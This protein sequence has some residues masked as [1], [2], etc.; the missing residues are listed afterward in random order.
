MALNPYF[1]NYQPEQNLVEDITVEVIKATGINCIYVPREYLSIDRVFGED[2]G[3][4]FKDSYTIEMYLQSYKGFEGTDV[5]S[6]FGLEIRDKVLLVL[7]R[8][9]FKEE[10]TNKNASIKR[11]REGD[12]IYFPLSK[13]LFE[14]NFVEH[15]N[16]LYPLGKLYSYA[17]TAELF[18]YSY[19]KMATSN[20]AINEVYN[21]T[22]GNA[23]IDIIPNNS[24]L[25]TTAGINDVLQ[26]E[27]EDYGFD[28]NDPNY[29][30]GNCGGDSAEDHTLVIFT[31]GL[32]VGSGFPA[33]S[34]TSNILGTGY[35]P[36]GRISGNPA[37]DSAL[38]TAA[39]VKT[40]FEEN[41]GPLG[42]RAIMPFFIN[43]APWDPTQINVT[44]AAPQPRTVDDAFHPDDF[45][46]D[47]ANPSQ[48]VV[49]SISP[50][51]SYQNTAKYAGNLKFASPWF[52]ASAPRTKIIWENWLSSLVAE[53]ITFD[54][55]M[56]NLVDTSVFS[57]VSYWAFNTLRET[58]VGDVPGKTLH[59]NHILNDPRTQSITSG[60]AEL[61]GS[62][63]DQLKINNGF[64]LTDFNYADAAEGVSAGYV[65]WNFVMSRL[66]SDYINDFYY[67]PIA[68]LM[69]DAQVSNYGNFIVKKSTQ[70]SDFA[71]HKQYFDNKQGNAVGAICYGQMGQIADNGQVNP[72]TPSILLYV[73][74][75]QNTNKF[76]YDSNNNKS[77]WRCMQLDQQSLKSYVRDGTAYD[78]LHVWVK[79]ATDVIDSAFGGN[80][81]VVKRK[82][83]YRENVYHICMIDPEVIF[84]FNQ[85]GGL[86]W[87]GTQMFNNDEYLTDSIEEVNSLK[88]NKRATPLSQCENK[89]D[90]SAHFLAS[91]CRL[92]NG[93]NLFRITTNY[94]KVNTLIV[95]G[96]SYDV[97]ETPGIWYI[98]DKDII[99]FEQTSYN[100]TTK[101]LEIT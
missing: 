16:P 17:I 37:Y 62:L 55:F 21:K 4:K 93:K 58:V 68:S 95:R 66:G 83:Y 98:A 18:T 59:M 34:S 45:C 51:P 99:D 41:P 15:E 11:P 24:M 2:P 36:Y 97:S 23:T 90:Y 96:T 46:R 47:P 85:Y 75:D 7:S 70:L 5:I 86:Q 8:K 29:A 53:G 60:N 13:S 77:G 42:K 69:P 73:P 40:W 25:G 84:Y 91:G 49:G 20:A 27:A 65:H 94:D 6:Q 72:S 61:Y 88:N 44:D 56:G 30:C 101:T 39:E 71:G 48:Y 12:L 43:S 67:T 22:R 28:P 74:S 89:L 10:V 26:D 31:F 33:W 76:G 78:H 57:P 82:E 38:V 80:L 19:E 9:R 1:S 14:I 87:D 32:G 35:Y 52:D 3:T 79:S 81:S 50:R 63:Y 54:Y 100:V 64:T 92:Y